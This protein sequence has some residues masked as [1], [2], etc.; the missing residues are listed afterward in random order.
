MPTDYLNFFKMANLAKTYQ[1]LLPELAKEMEV[2]SLWEVPRIKKVV[3]NV[4]LGEAVED[5]NAVEKVAAVLMAITG[6]KPKEAKA[7]QAISGFKLRKGM[8]IGLVVTLRGKRMYHF[9]EKLFKIVLPRLRDFQ[10]V[11]LKS[12]DGRGNYSIG[13]SDQSV[14][15]EVDYDK[16]DKTRGMEITLVTNTNSDEKSKILLKSLGV[17]FKE[18]EKGS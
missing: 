18:L 4:G 2:S 17:R 10:G 12:F 6:Q 3:I 13:L 8:P 5:K 7:R 1:E 11:S 16:V 15:P 9:L 14:F